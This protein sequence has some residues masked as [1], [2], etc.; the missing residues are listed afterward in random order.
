MA[1]PLKFKPELIG[2]VA[3]PPEFVPV[4]YIVRYQIAATRTEHRLTLQDVHRAFGVRPVIVA[5]CPSCAAMRPLTDFQ[6]R[7]WR[8]D[9]PAIR[10]HWKAI[11]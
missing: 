7:Y 5:D 2:A 11:Y 8:N 3:N 6:E 10:A 4:E 9:S 1:W